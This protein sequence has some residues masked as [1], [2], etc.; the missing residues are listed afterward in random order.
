[1]ADAVT[2]QTIPITRDSIAAA[3]RLIRPH[4]RRTPVVAVDATEF[5]LAPGPLMFKLEQL[6]HSGSSVPP[7]LR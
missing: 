2:H 6:Q 1:M 7:F 3:E 5:G 4:V